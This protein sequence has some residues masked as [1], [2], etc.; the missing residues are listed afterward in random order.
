MQTHQ[1]VDSKSINLGGWA[2][3]VQHLPSKCKALSANP[4]PFLKKKK[5]KKDEFYYREMASQSA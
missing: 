2:Q 3:E 5:K 1:T 4:R